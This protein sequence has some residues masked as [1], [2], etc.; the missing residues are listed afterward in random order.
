MRFTHD[1]MMTVA[2]SRFIRDGW[3]TF[4]GTGLPMVAAYLAKA[5]HA[6]HAT[7]MF[8]SGILAPEPRTVARAVV[9]M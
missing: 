6:T 8:E 4:I 3:N 2:T 7:L 1:E 5:T 9:A